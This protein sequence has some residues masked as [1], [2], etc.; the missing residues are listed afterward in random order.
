MAAASGSRGPGSWWS[1]T[2][3]STPSSR[4]SAASSTLP[5]PQSTVT[6]NSAFSAASVRTASQ[7]SP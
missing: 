1:V 4:A 2:I 3:S 5:M 6:S 7:F